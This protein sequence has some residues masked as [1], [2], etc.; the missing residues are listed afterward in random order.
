[1]S[2]N[3][4]KKL[5]KQKPAPLTLANNVSLIEAGNLEDDLL[6]IKRSGLDY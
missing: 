4:L 5:I 3:A 1:M 6:E 2:E